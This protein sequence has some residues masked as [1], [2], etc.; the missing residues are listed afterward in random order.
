[1]NIYKIYNDIIERAK[2]RTLD[3]SIYTE[4]H[5]INPKCLIGYDDNY[6]V[7]LT[8]K[9][10][11]ICHHLLTK[12]HPENSK[13]HYAFWAMCNQKSLGRN[14]KISSK[15]YAIAKEN[16]SKYMSQLLSGIPLSEEVKQ[17]LSKPRSNT[18]NMKKPKSELHKINNGLSRRKYNPTI[19]IC[20]QCKQ[21]WLATLYLDFSK[22]Y[23]SAS[24][25]NS[26]KKGKLVITSAEVR[27]KINSKLKNRKQSQETIQA[28]TK[29]LEKTYLITNPAGESFQIKG[30][31]GFCR[32]NKLTSGLMRAVATGKQTHHKGWKCSLIIE[33]SHHH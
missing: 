14:Y 17:K 8:A 20:P 29:K 25:Y 1:M 4:K 5:H 12:M 28:R 26:S 9:E 19:K 32:E 11:F 13:L 22:K 15:I 33:S 7:I 27:Q 16:H 18:D 6:T 2:Q 30:L 10:H 23:C 24:C 21:E 3:K 31:N